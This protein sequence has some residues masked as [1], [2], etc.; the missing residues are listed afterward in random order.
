[1]FFHDYFK[2]NKKD[3]LLL[4]LLG[5]EILSF[6]NHISSDLKSLISSILKANPEERLKMDEIFSHSWV[7]T[8]YQASNYYERFELKDNIHSNI[9]NEEYLKNFE[10]SKKEELKNKS[11]FRKEERKYQTNIYPN[12]IYHARFELQKEHNEKGENFENFLSQKDDLKN[13]ESKLREYFENYSSQKNDLKTEESKFRGG[14]NRNINY[15]QRSD[16]NIEETKRIKE[17]GWTPHPS[18]H[19]EKI[20]E[21]KLYESKKLTKEILP[22][23]KILEKFDYRTKELKEAKERLLLLESQIDDPKK[24]KQKPISSEG[25]IQKHDLKTEDHNNSKLKSEV[26]FKPNIMKKSELKF[27]DK[28]LIQDSQPE[29]TFLKSNNQLQYYEKK[30]SESNRGKEIDSQ[31]QK[32]FSQFECA[33]QNCEKKKMK[34]F[35]SHDNLTQM[36]DLKVDD[37]KQMKEDFSKIHFQQP[38]SQILDSKKKIEEQ[39]FL[40]NAS[41]NYF[42]AKSFLWEKENKGRKGI[43]EKDGG[44]QKKV[45]RMMEGLMKNIEGEEWRSM[46]LANFRG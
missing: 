43:F 9:K 14:W 35:D 4:L 36:Y 13:K 2:N 25:Q 30:A 8:L 41:H 7:K 26:Y 40:K 46:S 32:S 18:F 31:H 17:E 20:F 37:S 19:S 22:S 1:M 28:F 3:L 45:V 33:T 34:E 21:S 12:T 11:D 6:G 44:E 23:K 15:D 24:F 29:K 42:K 10:S 39:F 38:N 27:N 16:S 5:K